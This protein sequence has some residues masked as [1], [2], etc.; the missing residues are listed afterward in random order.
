MNLIDNAKAFK[1]RLLKTNVTRCL[2]KNFDWKVTRSVS[3]GEELS[4]ADKQYRASVVAEY[5][6]R[7]TLLD[8]ATTLEQVN[9]ITL[10]F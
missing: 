2:N 9:S 1:K 6:R 5:N 8:E 3:T 7:V 4:D 10:T